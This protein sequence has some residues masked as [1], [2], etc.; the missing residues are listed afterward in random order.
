MAI[1]A[2]DRAKLVELA[3]EAVRA[4]VTDRRLPRV[5]EATGLLAERRGCF[6]TL[7]NGG[8]LRGCI[9]TFQ[10]EVPLGEMIVRMGAAAARD[11]RFVMNPI[12]SCE[13]PDLTI[14]VSVLSELKETDQPQKLTVGTDGIYIVSGSRSG[15][16]LPEVA[17][18]MGW[19]AEEF[20]DHC[21]ISKAGLPADAWRRQDTRVYLFTSE[22][23]SG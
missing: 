23:F 20:L 15:C 22:K 8:Q 11:P 5:D 18:D 3:R 7:T 13:L 10:P 19:T 12:V 4:T 21:C 1:S 6:V 2:E 16:F 17:T 9:G 14:E